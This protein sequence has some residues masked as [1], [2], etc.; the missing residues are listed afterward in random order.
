MGFKQLIADQCVFIKG[1]GKD[2]VILVVWVDD[3]V[4]FSKRLNVKAKTTFDAAIRA[5]F[6]V[7]PWTTGGAGWLLNIR[8]E[9]DWET[10]TV[11]LS[12]R[13]H[14]EKV[15]KQ[16]GLDGKNCPKPR[17]P[18]FTKH[19]LCK[20]KDLNQIIPRSKFDY[21]SAVGA[22]LYISLTTRPDVAYSVGVL[23][24]FMACPTVDHVAAAKR[25]ISYLYGRSLEYATAGL[26]SQMQL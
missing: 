15:A 19:G 14:I 1:V 18:M 2:Q 21:M 8:I 22:L 26:R 23:R 11:H 7:S 4:M 20:P 3:I 12:Q 10:G 16:F 17:Y 5:V 9:R 25:V 6:E 13:A 24:R